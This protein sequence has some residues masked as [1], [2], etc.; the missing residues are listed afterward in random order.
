MGGNLSILYHHKKTLIA[1]TW[2]P[3]CNREWYLVS[4]CFIVRRLGGGAI[5]AAATQV[6]NRFGL[7]APVPENDTVPSEVQ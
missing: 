4:V 6:G 1:F 3:V 7:S 2:F 5:P